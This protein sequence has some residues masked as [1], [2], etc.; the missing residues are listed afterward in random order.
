MVQAGVVSVAAPSKVDAVQSGS[1]FR[2]T[3]FSIEIVNTDRCWSE[4]RA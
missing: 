3:P 4:I 1:P 2:S